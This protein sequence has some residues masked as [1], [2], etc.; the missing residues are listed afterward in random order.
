MPIGCADNLLLA[1]RAVLHLHNELSKRIFLEIDIR[2]NQKTFAFF[3]NKFIIF[4]Y[5]PELESVHRMRGGNV[6]SSGCVGK[7]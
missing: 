5:K 3:K 2:E 6:A 7:G 1:R 4:P